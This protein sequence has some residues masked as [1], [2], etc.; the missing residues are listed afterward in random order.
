MTNISKIKF[1]VFSPPPPR[2]SRL[3]A[4]DLQHRVNFA[5]NRETFNVF[6]NF[7][8]YRSELQYIANSI[9]DRGA[10]DRFQAPDRF[11]PRSSVNGEA[12]IALGSTCN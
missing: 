5:Y 1:D 12:G 9:R 11:G 4:N 8:I 7:L 2:F 3:S 10:R 6:R